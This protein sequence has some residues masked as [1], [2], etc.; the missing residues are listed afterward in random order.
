VD[1]QEMTQVVFTS[2]DILVSCG[3]AAGYPAL[4]AADD[5][6]GMRLSVLQSTQRL[7]SMLL[8]L[9]SKRCTRRQGQ[10]QL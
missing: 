10:G 6:A 2:S 7:D 5:V 1:L 3:S 9:K 4:D 8:P